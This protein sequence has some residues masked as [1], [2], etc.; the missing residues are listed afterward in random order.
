MKKYIS[1]VLAICLLT[2]IIHIPV[3]AEENKSDYISKLAEMVS[4]YDDNKYFGSITVKIGESDLNIDGET[5]PIDT[6]GSCAYVENG[7]TMLPVRGIAEAMGAEVSYNERDEKV[8]ILSAEVSV[9]MVVGENSMTVNGETQSLRTAPEIKNDRTMLPMRDVAE[10]LDCEVDWNG[11]TETVLLTKKYQTKRIIVFDSDLNDNAAI[12]KI[13]TDDYTVFQYETTADAK[14]AVER[15]QN[16]G[17]RAEPDCIRAVSSL[18]WGVDLIESKEYAQKTQ[19]RGKRCVVAVVDSGIDYNHSFFS[20]RITGGY[21]IYNNDDYCEDITGHG[22]HVSS[23]IIDVAED[24]SNVKVMP[25]KVFGSKETTSD[26]MVAAGIEYAADNGADV[27]NLSL[28]GP[29]ESYLEK[30]AIKKAKQKDIAVIAAAGNEK[31]DISQN[32]CTP[33]CIDGVIAVSAVNSNKNLASFSNYG[34]IDF[35]APGVDV[36][37]A[38]AGGGYVALSGT[39]MATPHVAGVYALAKSAHYDL[40]MDDITAALKRCANSNGDE[41]YFGAGIISLKNLEKEL[42]Y[43]DEYDE[44]EPSELRIIPE[45]YPTGDMEQGAGFNLSGRIKS[46]YHITDVRSYLLDSNQNVVQESSGWTTT[47]TYVIE[48]SALDTGLEFEKLLSGTYYL[49]YSASDESGNSVSWT[50]NAFTVKSAYVPPAESEL[51]ILPGAYPAGSISSGNKFNLSGRIKSNYHITDVRSYLL[52]SNQ[53][54]VQESSGWT[55]TR[56][57]VIEGSALD[58]GLK[59]ENL[60]P[61]T[62]YLKYS[63]SDESGNSV[64]WT[65]NAFTVESAYVPPAEP[66]VSGVVLIPD[67]FEN[68]SIRTGPST[69]YTIV[70]SMNNTV[71][72]NVYTEKTQNGWYY[73]E[74]NGIRG[75]A[76]GNYIYLPS[77]TRYGIVNIPSSWD[78]LSIRTGPSTDYNIIGSMNNGEGCTVYTDKARNGWYFVEHI[79]I[80][81]FAAGNR[82]DLR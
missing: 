37:G 57:Y 5:M 22:S 66:S 78:N 56:T 71:R 70:G 18:S 29:N 82:I 16:Q 1:T 46:N 80:F 17:Y 79:G 81:G 31:L 41:R 27:I 20:N 25:I 62:Y 68:L 59:F 24:N 77:E 26:T 45:S 53:N 52:D 74:Y 54:V 32:Y 61:G 6:S 42:G 15:F 76:A 8:S 11:E 30:L 21:D 36:K 72:C 48:G 55:T 28:G 23:T 43:D 47:R 63:A 60:S 9:Q 2:A 44:P 39:S 35:A 7:R 34:N 64:S 69:D 33:A 51:E 12:E 10:A 75:Y 3:K 73:V 50:S 67:S 13:D 14:E 58:T 40:S 38:R 19:A 49:K 4:E 65:S